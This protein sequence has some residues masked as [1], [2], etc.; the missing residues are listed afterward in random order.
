MR[1]FNDRYLKSLKPHPSGRARQFWDGAC[2][3]LGVRVSG[4]TGA[5]VFYLV[6]RV[7][8]PQPTWFR[9][10]RYPYQIT[11]PEARARAK[12]LLQQI[13]EGH[14]PHQIAARKRREA[15]A[16]ARQ[17]EMSTFGAIAERYIR[18]VE[19][20]VEDGK[21]RTGAVII[22]RVRRELL[23]AFGTCPMVDI[24]HRDI[25][26]F[27]NKIIERGRR[28]TPGRRSG[29]RHAARH[30]LAVLRQLCGWAMENGLI[31]TDPCARIKKPSHLHGLTKTDLQR[32]R[33]LSDDE[34]RAV[35]HA[36][37]QL[38]YPFGPLV[39]LLMLTGCRLRELSHASWG[40][41]LNVEKAELVIPPE[42]TK[43]KI[44]HVVPLSSLAQKIVAELPRFQNGD[45]VFTN[46]DG[47]KPLS[48]FAGPK[49]KLDS[50]ANVP[51]FTLHDLRR[52]CRTGLSSIR[53]VDDAVAEAI[54]GH[55][56]KG[57]VGVYNRYSY[58]DEKRQALE[59]WSQ[60]VLSIVGDNVVSMAR[61]V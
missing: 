11:L 37:D 34:V 39:K 5:V 14:N 1:A 42:R 58:A 13:T 57:I 50:L 3:N 6:R 52:T 54:L 60:K 55:A 36:A 25:V 31:D 27:V 48:S 21:L 15:E 29:G 10:G 28:V 47:S 30:A 26:G 51:P 20:L 33:V 17:A 22:D 12:E 38:N 59:A 2:P 56:P 44:L 8:K 43:T 7:N 9:L 45:F 16:A 35:W 32:S 18:H 49:A 46:Q 53:G 24:S 4:T 19:G 41:E 40:S 61:R 23:P